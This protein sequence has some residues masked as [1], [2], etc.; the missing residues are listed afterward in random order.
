[1]EYT[2]KDIEAHIREARKLRSEAMGAILASGWHKFAQLVMS[3]M[4]QEMPDHR[5]AIKF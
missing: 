5:A 4:H 3:V 2:Y 1:M